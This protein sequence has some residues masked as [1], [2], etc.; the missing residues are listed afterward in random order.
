MYVQVRKLIKPV[1]INE[2]QNKGNQRAARDPRIRKVLIKQP[3]KNRKCR[4]S[5]RSKC[6]QLEKV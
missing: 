2:G 3:P 4:K 5:R 1:P 6:K